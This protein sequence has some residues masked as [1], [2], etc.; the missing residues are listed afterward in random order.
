MDNSYFEYHT[1]K[2]A[3][4]QHTNSGLKP[5]SAY[6]IIDRKTEAL[7]VFFSCLEKTC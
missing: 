1:A 2:A 7:K 5:A 4:W 3:D 6:E